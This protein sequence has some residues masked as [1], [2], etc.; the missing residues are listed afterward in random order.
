[1]KNACHNGK[2]SY[3]KIKGD[4]ICFPPVV[5]AT[6]GSKGQVLPSQPKSVPPQCI[7]YSIGQHYTLPAPGCKQFFAASQKLVSGRRQSTD[8]LKNPVQQADS[9]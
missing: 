9:L 5:L 7:D 1:M 6:S 4:F 3:H 2:H 8:S